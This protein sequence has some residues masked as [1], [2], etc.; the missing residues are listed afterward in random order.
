MILE[1]FPD[2]IIFPLLDN[3]SDEA[4]SN[5]LDT[6]IQSVTNY[7]DR[8]R[9]YGGRDS[10]IPY[11]HGIYKDIKELVSSEMISGTALRLEAAKN[12]K[13]SSDL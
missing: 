1:L 3:P 13:S 10:F 6:L 2:V 5:N 11:Y 9:L 4:W 7:K 12:V 8:I